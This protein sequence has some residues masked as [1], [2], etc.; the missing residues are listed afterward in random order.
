MATVRRWGPQGF[1]A[2]GVGLYVA[3]FGWLTWRQQS[4]YG[5]FGYDMGLHDQGIWLTSRF[6]RPF[7][8]IRGMHYF[9]HHVNLVSLLYVPFYRLGA[10]PHFLYLTETV[11]LAAGA[12]P[13]WLLAR[14]RLG[15][16]WPALVPAFA[17]LLYPS[18]EWM[19]WWHWHPEA[20]AV[21]PLLF[22]WWFAVRRRWGWFGLCVGLALSTKEDVALAV[23]MLGV[24][25]LV[26]R[27]L[28]R[29]RGR[30]A[31]R[32]AGA[33]T[34]LAGLVWFLV[35]TRLII[36]PLLDGIPF[37]E[38]QL[39]PQFGDSLGSVLVG[40]VTS[41]GKVWAMATEPD[42]LTYYARLLGP[43]GFVAPLLGAPFLL[44]AGPQ[45]GVNVLS[46]LPG[47][48][49]IRFQYSAV[50]VA[51]VFIATVEAL[52]WLRRW[53]S[54]LAVVALVVI[55]CTAVAGNAAWSPSPLGRD[56]DT[57]IWAHRIPR[58]AAFDA[59]VALVPKGAGVSATY[60][61]IPHLTHR[62]Y[63]YEWPNP[64]ILGNWGVHNEHP[65]D[66]ATAE[67]LVLDTTLRQEPALL[68]SL[69]DSTYD[70]VFSR[71]GVIVA[72]HR[73]R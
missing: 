12:V 8:T 69:T 20:L 2:V 51:A 71:D 62:R 44:I 17:F 68:A 21:T 58:H 41:P 57:G 61:L 54:W 30:R 55:G 11:V 40:I 47:T 7:V 66:V 39:F 28:R 4:A 29:G 53:R 18:I 15:S 1:L 72:R 52:G 3:V 16:A 24:V 10:G 67:Y 27:G 46:S 64:F 34:A 59:A 50:V 14:D 70:V 56:F 45:L 25:L 48:H 65:P 37:Y 36:P 49:D 43:L 13:V 19:N 38:R 22:A 63:A 35:C 60:Y 73:A 31:E 26:M 9:G 6:E 33:L 42:R 32:R 5:T 23:M